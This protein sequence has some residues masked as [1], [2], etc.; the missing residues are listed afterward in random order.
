MLSP[1]L[2]P[3]SGGGVIVPPD[4]TAMT[5]LICPPSGGNSF[6]MRISPGLIKLSSWGR[7]AGE[8]INATVSNRVASSWVWDVLS[9]LQVL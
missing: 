7:S 9:G 5:L 4:V 3:S 8:Y 6:T 1:C 2:I